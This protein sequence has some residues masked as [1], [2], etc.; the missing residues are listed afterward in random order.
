MPEAAEEFARARRAYVVAAAGCGKTEMVARAAGIHS[1][2]RQL[3]LTHTH[4]AV[5][6]LKDRLKRVGAA[7]GRVQIETIA[8]F[9][10]HYAA[11]FPTS[12]RL[13]T[14]EPTTTEEW[15]ATYEAARRVLTG[16]MG[17]TVLAQSYAGMYVDEYQDCVVPQHDLV[18][19]MADVLPCRVVLDPLQGIFGFAGPLI[20]CDVHLD[21]TF[22]RLDDLKTPWRWRRCNPALGDWLMEVREDLANGQSINL[23]DA[24]VSRGDPSPAGQ[25]KACIQLVPGHGSVVA[26]GRWPADCHTMASRLSGAF[27]AMEPI[28]CPDLFAWA[29]KIEQSTGG[30]RAAR[31]IDFAA[32]CMTRVVTVLRPARNAFWAQTTPK[33]RGSPQVRRAIEELI[34]VSRQSTL[35]P[36][37]DAMTAIEQISGR[38]LHRRELWRDMAKTLRSYCADEHPTLSLAAWRTRDRGRHGRRVEHR[39]VSRTLLVKGL[40]FDHAVVLNGDGHDASNLYVAL[41]RGSTSLTILSADTKIVPISSDTRRDH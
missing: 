6:A 22:Q 19:V 3:V 39:T 11:S 1:E 25:I 9:A 2:G 15:G 10:L 20:S 29:M 21:P 5:K 34:Q 16:R 7:P 18:L 30:T 24:P 23:D 8:G 12:S 40:E 31:V 37:V 13:P 26:I 4:A 36:V 14:A 28:E 33:L 17:R 32:G 38:V 41:T 35:T 27:T